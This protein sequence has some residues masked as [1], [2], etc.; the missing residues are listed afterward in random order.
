VDEPVLVVVELQSALVVHVEDVA[1]LIGESLHELLLLEPRD[2]FV[3]DP[4]PE[5]ERVHGDGPLADEQRVEPSHPVLEVRDAHAALRAGE[6]RHGDQ[7]RRQHHHRLRDPVHQDLARRAEG[8]SLRAAI[9]RLPRSAERRPD[10]LH[11]QRIA[12]AQVDASHLGA[13]D[14]RRLHDLSRDPPSASRR[15]PSSFASAFR[16]ADLLVRDA[17][18]AG[19]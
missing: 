16:S 17:D 15:R 11:R 3:D 13:E 6:E 9:E 18:R 14:L 5:V 7:A 8:F 4:V 1:L 19:T 10:L 12:D 2:R